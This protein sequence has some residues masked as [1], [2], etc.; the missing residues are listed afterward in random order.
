[1]LSLICPENPY[2]D[3]AAD[4][5]YIKSELSAKCLAVSNSTVELAEKTNNSIKKQLQTKGIK[6]AD[7]KK[8]P[9]LLEEILSSEVEKSCF[10]MEKAGV[11]GV[12]S[13]STQRS[14]HSLNA[15]T[16]ARPGFISLI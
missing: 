8:H 6:P 13:F 16:T 1:M 11:T 9:E 12:S 5:E 15:Q 3:A 2:Y 7:L 4:L 10:I 14:T